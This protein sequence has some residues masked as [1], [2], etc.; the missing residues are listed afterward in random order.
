MASTIL[1][2]FQ[3]H[4]FENQALASMPSPQHFSDDFKIMWKTMEW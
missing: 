2:I 4:E 1:S 3:H